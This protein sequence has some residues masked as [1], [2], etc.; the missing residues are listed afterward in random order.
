MK[1]LNRP[2]LGRNLSNQS[3]P[4][5][6]RSTEPMTT[7]PSSINATPALFNQFQGPPQ[8]AYSSEM[9]IRQNDQ[10]DIMSNDNET[11]VN[12]QSNNPV[13]TSRK[14]STD[15]L[16]YPRKRATI[17]VI[18]YHCMFM[19]DETNSLQC[20]LCRGR[21]S[22]CDGARPRC[23]LCIELRIDCV[24]R[25]PGIK[26]TAGEKM[27]ME[28]LDKMKV[29]LQATL[30]GHHRGLNVNLDPLRPDD[31]MQGSRENTIPGAI[32]GTDGV[33]S[34]PQ[35]IERRPMP[36]PNST[37]YPPQTLPTM[38]A[39]GILRWPK[40]ETL[41]VRPPDPQNLLQVEIA[42]EPLHID[43]PLSLDLE[44][45][46]RLIHAF[47]ERVNIWYA[48]VNPHEWAGYYQKAQ[49]VLFREGPESCVV[50]FVLALGSASFQGSISQLP[51]ASEASGMQYFSAA[52]GL[53]SNL[54]TSNSII[55]IQCS[56]LAAAYLSYL[57]RP[58]E[59]W[60]L[61]SNSSMKMQLLLRV[62]GAIPVQSMQL[63]ERLYW[64]ILFAESD[65]ITQLD[66]PRSG[67]TQFEESVALPTFFQAFQDS[68]GRD[69]LWYFHAAI[70]LCRLRTRISQEI[71]L[72]E[73][74]SPD[75]LEPISHGLEIQLQDWYDNLPTNFRF[76]L[77]RDVL[78]HPA[79]IVLR[80]R[81]FAARTAIFRPYVLAVL[82]DENAFGVPFIRENCSKCLESCI[83][84]I[85]D[86][87]ADRPDYV[88]YLWQSALSLVSQTLLAMGASMSPSLLQY[89]PPPKHLD[90]LLMGA[91]EEVERYTELAP[92]LRICAQVLRGIGKTQELA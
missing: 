53:L 23:K 71:S 20:E 84:Q 91:V 24:Y 6:A 67:I 43:P 32:A 81:Y 39:L 85:E 79:Q 12:S 92:S 33:L 47:F 73:S 90:G 8:G 2:L 89:L 30:G 65:V 14:R 49:S 72:K 74:S 9:G 50:L 13:L 86:V 7:P 4:S 31:M 11:D 82:E 54:I 37:F 62:P 66:L 27:I 29:F 78:L 5:N 42:R 69:E 51:K 22:R 17:A 35:A 75:A 38:S 63:S 16:G 55:S 28:D 60:T 25:E 36:I 87:S 58:L 18:F 77:N 80:S 59:A 1:S 26:L 45:T 64:N 88:P 48:C 56:I 83:R 41:V 34:T 3:S 76:H 15:M 21:K 70:D 40:M 61:I 44:D 46:S 57:V 10:S 68:P 19:C 52:W